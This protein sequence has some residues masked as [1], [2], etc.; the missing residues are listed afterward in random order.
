LDQPL[1]DDEEDADGEE[2]FVAKAGGDLARSGKSGGKAEPVNRAARPNI[3]MVSGRA[4]LRAKARRRVRSM[5]S[6][7]H[8]SQPM[9]LLP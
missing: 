4:Q 8:A 2:G 6:V 9:R 5:M 1:G 3:R 7:V